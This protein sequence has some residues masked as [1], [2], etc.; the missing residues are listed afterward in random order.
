MKPKTS[1]L[2]YLTLFCFIFSPS[3]IFA[4]DLKPVK[5]PPPRTDGGKPLMQ[6]LKER[7][8]SRSF[9]SDTIPVQVMSDLLWAAWGINRPESGR[10]TAPSASN[11]QE[12]DVYVITAVGVYV[13]DAAGHA[14][15]P[16]LAGDIREMAGTQPWVKE[17]PVNLIYVADFSKMGSADDNQKYSTSSANTGFISENVYLYCAS[18]RL[19]TVVR[20]SVDKTALEAAMKLRPEQKVI[21]GQTVGYPKKEE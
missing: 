11:K 1:L 17:A 10:R 7:N 12:I 18:E 9:S 2:I 14:L 19:A 21:L 16:V 20:G 8:S 4:Q 13:Y 3:L 5:L 6:V 15:N